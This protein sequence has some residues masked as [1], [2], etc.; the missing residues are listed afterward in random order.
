MWNYDRIYRI[1][2]EIMVERY[3]VENFLYS[4]CE[5]VKRNGDGYVLRC[6]IC[7]DSKKSLNKRR[8]HVDYY[9]KFDEWIYKCYNGGCPNNSGNIQSLFSHVMAVSWK[10][11]NDELTEKKYDSEKIKAKLDNKPV[12]IDEIDQQGTLDLDLNDCLCLNQKPSGRIQ[13]RYHNYLK[14]FY[15]SRWI[16]T[17]YNIMVAHSGKYKNR[18]IIPV[19]EDDEMI[20]FQGRAMNNDIEPKYF[21]PYVIKENIVLNRKSFD[22]EKY[23]IVTEGL[24]DAYMVEYNQGTSCLG[25]SVSDE[26]LEK[27]IPLSKKGIII[28]LDNPKTDESGYSNYRKII[29]ESKYARILNYFYMPYIEYKDLNDLRINN[30]DIHIYN[31]IVEKSISHFKASIILKNVI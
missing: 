30:K 6:P 22:L 2:R 25:A 29:E 18:F 8:C 14:K 12:Y 26:F 31:F 20:Y 4:N 10:E 5:K 7:G 13:E 23:I 15:I 3:L 19:Y 11:A 16:P 1:L 21:N 9:A 27:I 24:I 28:A 17:R